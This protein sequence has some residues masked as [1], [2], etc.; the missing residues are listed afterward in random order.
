M[1]GAAIPVSDFALGVDEVNTIV[2]AIQ[3]ELGQNASQLV[4]PMPTAVIFACGALFHA[5]GRSREGL[6]LQISPSSGCDDDHS[7]SP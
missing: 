2:K 1:F 3:H 7:F 4:R 6:S 5:F